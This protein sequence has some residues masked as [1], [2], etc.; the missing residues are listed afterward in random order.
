[1]EQRGAPWAAKLLS[2]EPSRVRKLGRARTQCAVRVALLQG[3]LGSLRAVQKFS[4]SE[5]FSG[6]KPRPLLD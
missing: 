1:M 3:F 2:Q 5:K 6:Q 4:A